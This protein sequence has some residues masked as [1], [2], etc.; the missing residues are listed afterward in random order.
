MPPLPILR[1]NFTTKASPKFLDLGDVPATYVGQ[2]LKNVRVN[3]GE[4]GL[5]FAAGGGT[6]YFNL[7]GTAYIGGDQTGNARGATALDVQST[8]SNV[9]QVA[10]GN[11]ASAFGVN[12]TA[13]GVGSVSIGNTNLASQLKSSAIGSNCTA[14]ANYATAVGSLCTASGTE[15]FSAGNQCSATA[16]HAF[17]AGYASTA[18]GS[19]STALGSSCTASVAYSFAAGLNANA[20][21][22]FALVA[23][24]NSTASG[25]YA[26]AFGTAATASGNNSFC[27]GSNSSAT[28]QYAFVAGANSVAGGDFSTALGAYSTASGNYS[29]SVGINAEASADYGMAIGANAKAAV[30]LTCNVSVPIINQ[31]GDGL[32]TPINA[33]NG[34]RVVLMTDVYDLLGAGTVVMNIPTG[35]HFYPDECGIIITTAAVV[36]IQPT[37]S[38]GN[39]GNHAAFL[40]AGLT[41]G[42]TA[43]FKRQRFQTLLTADGQTTVAATVTVGATANSIQGRFY[44]T[45]L[46]VEDQ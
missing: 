16:I 24:V 44:F 31:K 4:T 15:S 33:F 36:T 29:F 35:A 7:V 8:R 27:A 9:T 32:S 46:M 18:G 40:A 42:L 45:G 28:G 22:P 13:S 6:S 2:S 20:S 41:T 38:F 37:V 43:A 39:T 25:Y 14:S 19:R 34:V 10:S 1:N 21:K 30:P 17:A 3:V 5:E 12:S 11:S 26:A 23:G